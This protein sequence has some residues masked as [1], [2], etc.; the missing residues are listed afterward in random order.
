MAGPGLLR[1]RTHHIV[2]LDDSASMAQRVG[3]GNI[4]K[5]SV[6]R[7]QKLANELVETGN[8]DLF[9]L[10]LASQRERQPLLF[11]VRVNAQLSKKIR[12]ALAAHSVGD[13]TLSPGETLGVA[14]KWA[15]EKKKDAGD[16][17]YY[18]VTDSRHH[19][20]VVDGKPA[21]G[22]LKHLQE[23]D[24][25]HAK[26]TTILVGP[27]ETENLGVAAV[28]R[29]DR[30]AMAG[31]SVTLEVEVRNFGD[32]NS[33][34]TEVAVEIDEK[35]RVVRPVPPI[36]AGGN[37][38]VDIDHT[39]RDPGFH[40]VVATLPKD[41][42]PVDDRGVLALEVVGSSQV[43]VVNG[44]QGDAPEESETF[45]LNKALDLGSDVITGI[46]V[47]EI[48]THSFAEY[49]LSHINMIWLAN[50]RAM[51][52]KEIQKLEAFV[53]GGGG[54]VMFLG[55]QV[56]VGDYNK[57]FYKD[58][59]GLMPLPV[60]Q[61][62]G[63][64]DNPDHAFV[65]DRSHFILEEN[66]EVLDVVLSRWVLVKRY[67][68]L[69]EAAE[70]DVAIPVRVKKSN[71]APLIAT[72]TFQRGG[73]VAVVTTTADDEW[74]D[75]CITPAFLV[76]CQ[77]L[78]KHATK[79]HA[80]APYNLD[81]TGRLRVEFDPAEYRRDVFVRALAGQGFEATYTSEDAEKSDDGK[82][83]TVLDVP[84]TELEGLGLFQLTMTPYRGEPEIRMLS[85]SAPVDE[86]KLQRL[87]KANWLRT[88]PKEVHDRLEVLE[89][90]STETAVSEVGEGELWRL[91]AAGLLTF[92]LLETVLAWRFGRR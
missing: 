10:L 61:L 32:E 5:T 64:A 70:P 74:C 77:E 83:R 57:A 41:K 62:S 15:L 65:A 68:E 31:T 71:G 46:D 27:R 6:N 55:D 69:D 90:S 23:M 30:L 73:Q 49:D 22:V 35:T 47:T 87:T 13:T 53:A 66:V 9:T 43:L 33:S 59:K 16:F 88:Y 58:G 26:L 37:A 1:A 85:R 12:D 21:P 24:A 67:Y 56:V 76:M 75:L 8:G 4:Y 45:F 38:V 44:D 92:L 54:L 11:A 7:I 28:R 72:K 89:E 14:K 3:A 29:R 42:Y 51:P 50:V 2:C 20:F 52:P 48:P 84:M 81:S 63:D 19:D 17:H 34:A 25:A 18:L 79:V 39:F 36:P 91:L 80:I 40:G 86:G 78:H 60:R 82:I